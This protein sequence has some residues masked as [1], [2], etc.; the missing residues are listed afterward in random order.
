MEHCTLEKRG[1]E[2][3][4][5]VLTINNPPVNALNKKVI[6]EIKSCLEVLAGD[7][8]IRALVI[9][10]E[11]RKAFMGGADIKELPSILEGGRDTAIA[12]AQNGH[13]MFDCVAK[14]IKPTIA[15]I[16]GFAL[17]AGCELAL[18]C[19]IRI[20]SSSALFGLPEINLGIMPGGGGTQRLQ[21]IIGDCHAKEMIFIGDSIDAEKAKTIGLVTKIVPQE[22]VL[23]EAVLLAEKIAGRSG[24]AIRAIKRCMNEGHELPIEEGLKMEIETFGDVFLSENAGIGV[25]AFIEKKKPVF[26]PC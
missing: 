15:A 21:R 18:A 25:A 24:I 4:V 16:N 19:D 2:S 23:T 22:D 9:V 10:G 8:S 20:A 17:G 7:D 3:A 12:Y 5:A 14:F 6:T 13:S 11:G 1:I 26:K